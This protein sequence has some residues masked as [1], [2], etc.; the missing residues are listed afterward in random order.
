MR[1]HVSLLAVAALTAA[2]AGAKATRIGADSQTGI[3]Q[4]VI[5]VSGDTT[6]VQRDVVA[7]LYEPADV[8]F[9]DPS[10]PR[11]LFLDTKGKIAF[12]IGG[13]IYATAAYNFAG[14]SETGTDFR[15]YSMPTPPN[16]DHRAAMQLTARHSTIFFQLAG[17]AGKLGQ[18]SAFL[19]TDFTGGSGNA[20]ELKLVQAYIRLG[21]VTAGLARSTFVDAA[22]IP[23][24]D[25]EG[26]CG[27]SD[28][29]NVQFQ[30]APRLSPHWSVAIAAEAAPGS[31][32]MGDYTHAIAQRVPDIP[33]YLRYNWG[34]QGDHV[35]VSGIFRN[36]CYRDEIT[37]KRRYTFGYGVQLSGYAHLGAGFGLY[38]NATYGR[39]IAG[40]VADLMSMPLN[41]VPSADTDGKLIAPRSFSYAAG[42]R[43]DFNAKWFATLAW[44]QAT[45]YDRGALGGDTYRTGKY[46]SANCFYNLFENCLLGIE[47]ARGY[48]RNFDGTTGSG[49]RIMAA[50]RYSF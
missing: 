23:T 1:K 4:R 32:S 26:P 9:H 5:V 24:V 35:R 44:G 12:G 18:F 34:E 43:Y 49:N 38:A 13:N 11:F 42:L 21:Y 46:F 30:Y 33:V 6:K 47:Y 45:L 10:A 39:G 3:P 7:V 19:Q 25:T 17:N 40:Y 2:T 37:G 14:S 15:P 36:M 16:P 29:K 22:S 20:H 48:R 28:A 8:S 27:I 50:V 31:S 41:M